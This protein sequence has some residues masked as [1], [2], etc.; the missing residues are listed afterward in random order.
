MASG[1]VIS[2]FALLRAKSS[3]VE[4][5]RWCWFS[6]VIGVG[7]VVIGVALAVLGVGL[8]VIGVGLTV[9]GVG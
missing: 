1:E 4:K 5:S 6:V 2:R 3:S 9:I 7:F 8:V